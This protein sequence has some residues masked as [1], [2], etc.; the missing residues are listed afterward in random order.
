MIDIKITAMTISDLLIHRDGRLASSI[1]VVPGPDHIGK[2]SQDRTKRNLTKA[3][4]IRLSLRFRFGGTFAH[5][6]LQSIGGSA[7][8]LVSTA[9]IVNIHNRMRKS[10]WI[11]A[12]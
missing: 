5:A 8:R 11:M 10:M 2:D 3:S 6:A 9:R 7:R 1:V 4:T 12:N